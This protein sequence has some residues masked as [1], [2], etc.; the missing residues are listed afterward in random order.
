MSPLARAVR[1]TRVDRPILRRSATPNLVQAQLR[2]LQTDLPP[3]RPPGRR[4]GSRKG[5]RSMRNRMS[6]RPVTAWLYDTGMWRHGRLKG[7]AAPSILA[8]RSIQ[9][10]RDDPYEPVVARLW[11]QPALQPVARGSGPRG[12]SDPP[13]EDPLAG[14][15]RNSARSC[16]ASSWCPHA[17]LTIIVRGGDTLPLPPFAWPQC[18]LRS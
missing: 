12:A 11:S 3:R 5:T 8:A 15:V 14:P 2:A 6:L 17:E 18:L 13:S 10:E 1:L 7:P 4:G 16:G 9:T